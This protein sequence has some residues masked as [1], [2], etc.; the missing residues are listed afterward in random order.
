MASGVPGGAVAVSGV[1]GIGPHHPSDT[2]RAT[3]LAR[4]SQIENDTQGTGDAGARRIGRADQ[5]AHPLILQRSIG[6]RGTQPFI[7]PAARH[8]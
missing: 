8:V 4:V 2:R 6:E 3:G 5:A 1:Q 7:E